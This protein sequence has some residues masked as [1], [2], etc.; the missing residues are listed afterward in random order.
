[1]DHKTKEQLQKTLQEVKNEV[2]AYELGFQPLTLTL[3]NILDITARVQ[4][5]KFESGFLII[6]KSATFGE[7]IKLNP[8]Q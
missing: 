4:S 6:A 8:Q 1:M 3:E 2:E 5:P 7:L